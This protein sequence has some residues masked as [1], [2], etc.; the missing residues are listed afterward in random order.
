[1][2]R[3]VDYALRILRALSDGE[4]ST[5]AQLC[6]REAIPK[7]FAYKTL[8]KLEK[9]GFVALTRGAAGGCKLC[10]DLREK[11]L[12]DLVSALD[13]QLQVNACMQADYQCSWREAHKGRPCLIHTQLSAIQQT[14]DAEL[15]RYSLSSILLGEEKCEL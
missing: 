4:L 13:A 1:M 5:A 7:Q 12:F 14:I 2:T 10:A 3:E 8:K 6:E 11:T 15:R 9:A